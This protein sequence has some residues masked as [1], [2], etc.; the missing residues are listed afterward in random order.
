MLK[1]I[2][3]YLA[4]ITPLNGQSDKP[5]YFRSYENASP[6]IEQYKILG[7]FGLDKSTFSLS[8]S[9][10]NGKWHVEIMNGRK[11]IRKLILNDSYNSIPVNRIVVTTSGGG[12]DLL[13]IIPFGK[14]HSEC[15]LNGEDVY[16]NIVIESSDQISLEHFPKCGLETIDLPIKKVGDALEIG[17]PPKQ[18]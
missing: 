15:F 6:A 10:Y 14:P 18:N 13:I 16:S 1:V 17:P 9:F 2:A 7:T 3:L 11:R 5:F 12:S 8:L 4:A